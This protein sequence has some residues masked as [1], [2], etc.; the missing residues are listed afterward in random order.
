MCSSCPQNQ[1]PH[2]IERVPLF[3]LL[4]DIFVLWVR[5]GRKTKEEEQCSLW[6]FFLKIWVF[7]NVGNGYNKK[8]IMVVFWRLFSYS[9]SICLNAKSSNIQDNTYSFVLDFLWYL[10]YS[11][12]ASW[13]RLY[14]VY[15]SLSKKTEI[16]VTWKKKRSP[17]LQS[18]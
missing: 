4:L 11:I 3:G 7:F 16:G 6:F 14:L 13:E 15:I 5:G 17:T 9:R 2:I 1:F 8:K 12:L 10:F 18:F